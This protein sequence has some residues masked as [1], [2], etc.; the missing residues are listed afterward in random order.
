MTVEA[1]EVVLTD[2]I[3]GNIQRFHSSLSDGSIIGHKFV[4]EK[5]FFMLSGD[6]HHRFKVSIFLVML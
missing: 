5:L 2:L 3:G 4:K 6:P 1:M